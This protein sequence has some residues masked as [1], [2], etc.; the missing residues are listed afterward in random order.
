[1][2]W[3]MS[4]IYPSKYPFWKLDFQ[5]CL[6]MAYTVLDWVDHGLTK[7]FCNRITKKIYKNHENPYRIPFSW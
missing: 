5:V 2:I 3:N 7:D 6:T 4:L 1:M